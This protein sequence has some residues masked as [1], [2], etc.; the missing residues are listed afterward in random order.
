MLRHRP[1]VVLLVMVVGGLLGV[2]VG[3]HAQALD[4][5]SLIGD[6]V[7]TWQGKLASQSGPYRLVIERVKGDKVQ[8]HVETI[9]GRVKQNAPTSFR[10]AGV[11]K[12]NHLT[13]GTSNY[14]V[15]L[16]VNGSEMRGTW[17]GMAHRDL[18]L[19]KQK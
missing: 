19:V 17:T 15:D 1:N 5:Q 7:G 11:V 8:G 4:P 13:Y 2:A 12:G 14:Q 3:G 6:W 18:T 9:S 16:E 10:I